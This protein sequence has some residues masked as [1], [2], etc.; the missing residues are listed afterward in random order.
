MSDPSPDSPASRPIV[1]LA[2]GVGGSKLAVGLYAHLG[3]RLTVVANTG[4]DTDVYGLRVCP[5]LDT[6]MYTLAG[7]ASSDTGWGVAGDTFNAL[8][9]LGRYGL[10][11]WFRIGDRDLATN[12]ARTILLASGRRLTEVEAE[13]ASRLGIGARLLPMCDQPIATRLRTAVGELEFQEYFVKRRHEDAITAVTYAGAER[14]G[15]SSE[16]RDA[17]SSAAAIVLCPSNPVVSIGPILAVPGL[18]DLLRGLNVPRVAV[19]PII[20]GAA[21]SGPA[22]QMMAALGFPVSVLGLADMYGDFL[23][24]IVIDQADAGGATALRERGLEVLVAQTMMKTPGDKR[25]LAG[26]VLSW[27]GEPVE[28]QALP[29]GRSGA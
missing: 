27:L 17:L 7:L 29:A 8:D 11:T 15:L 28:G 21:V 13:L 9:Q 10:D 12:L 23:T 25:R 4:D 1:A 16:T 14:A 6:L 22:G 18:R 5:D 2:G 19:S 3:Q 24:G 20:G 26:E